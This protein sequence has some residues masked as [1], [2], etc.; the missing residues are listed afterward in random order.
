MICDY[1]LDSYVDLGYW[2]GHVI[3][4]VVVVG[5]GMGCWFSCLGFL[6]LVGVLVVFE[7]EY[8]EIDVGQWVVGG[9]MVVQFLVVVVVFVEYALCVVGVGVDG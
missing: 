1:V 7:F 9:G 6:F 3:V 4:R 8:V 5:G 2:Y